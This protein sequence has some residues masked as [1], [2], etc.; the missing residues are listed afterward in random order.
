MKKLLKGSLFILLTVLLLAAC[1]GTDGASG[2]DAN[3]TDSEGSASNGDGVTL[4]LYS[5]LDENERPAFEEVVADFEESN[6]GI[7]MDINYPGTSY[8]DEL[9]VRMGANNM[10]DLFDTHGWA[11]LRYGEYTEDLGDMDWVEHFDSALEPILQDEEGKVYAYPLNQAKDGVMYN[12]NV[13]EEYGVEPPSTVDEFR[14]ISGHDCICQSPIH[15]PKS[16]F[17]V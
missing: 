4:S 16:R 13:L 7:Q 5:T 15:A 8:E 2:N 6:P 9:R 10:P 1:G 3:G 17:I 11:I 14:V 12:E